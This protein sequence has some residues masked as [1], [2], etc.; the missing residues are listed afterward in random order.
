M[1]DDHLS[2]EELEQQIRAALQDPIPDD[3]IGISEGLF[4]WRT[5]DAELAELELSDE[6]VGVR[7][8]DTTTFT[9]VIEDQVIE[10]EFHADRGELVVDLGGNWALGIRLVTP[11]DA[12][13]VGDIDDAGVAR[14][15]DPPTGPIQ[16]IISRVAGGVIKTRWVTL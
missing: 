2:D 3:L 16:L 1:S 9:F 8:E 5:I 11:S 14:F 4:T 10:V 13:I 12:Q 15:D 7:G 6:P